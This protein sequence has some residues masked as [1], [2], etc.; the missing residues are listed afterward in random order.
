M[1]GTLGFK[2][3]LISR[4]DWAVPLFDVATQSEKRNR[5]CLVIP[6]INEG[7]RLLVQLKKITSLGH[8]NLVDVIVADGGSDD[9]SI[10]LEVFKTLG[11][12]ATLVKRGPGK[13]SAQLR[14]AYAWALD[15]KGYDGIVTMDGNGKD[16]PEAI[17][18]FVS[19]L[20]RGV[21]YAQASRFI[22]GGRGVNTPL[23]RHLAVRLIHAPVSSLAARKW[24]TDTTQGFR[25]YS[26]RYLRDLRVQPFR[27]I[28][29][30]YELLAYLTIRAS[31]LGYTVEELPTTRAYPDDGSVP[32]KING[33]RGNLGLLRTLL[34]ASAGFY[35]PGSSGVEQ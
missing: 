7:S 5:Y 28:F 21:D 20:D 32:T 6:V 14:M 30:E 17:P 34:A 18:E 2:R 29:N 19:A 3:G 12:H 8:T 35:H 10:N 26:A 31:Q 9:G 27:K 24:L 16:S 33:T 22:L 13:L 11:V 1:D 4:K 15:Q 23:I 25:A